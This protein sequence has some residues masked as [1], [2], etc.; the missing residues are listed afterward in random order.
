[1]P[2]CAADKLKQG[3][4]FPALLPELGRKVGETP[5]E[6][7]AIL[8]KGPFLHTEHGGHSEIQCLAYS[9][10]GK[11]LASVSA[12]FEPTTTSFS[13]WEVKLWDADTGKPLR[14]IGRH[15]NAVHAIAFSPDSQHLVTGCRDGT[16][17]VWDVE[18]GKERLELKG[19]APRVRGVAWSPDGKWIAGCS[20]NFN[21][22]VVLWDAADGAKQFMFD[23]HGSGVLRVA[24]SPDSS[25]V[26]SVGEQG[27]GK[28]RV[29]ETVGGKEIASLT[30]NTSIPLRR[31]LQP[32]RQV[33][34]DRRP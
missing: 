13:R 6:L 7:V 11:R 31:G 4:I 18:T 29:W 30:C 26:A 12:R 16:V 25:L 10:D 27:D 22:P 9:P 28:V 21:T 8:G 23:K 19:L 1:M 20:D 14:D 34:G 3:E 2:P 24:F 5:V 17:K 33:P 15:A 32:Q